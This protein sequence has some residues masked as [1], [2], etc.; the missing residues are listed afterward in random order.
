MY[1]TAC[2]EFSFE[3][4]LSS[5]KDSSGVV[6]FSHGVNNINDLLTLAKEFLKC[7]RSSLNNDLQNILDVLIR[8]IV[9]ASDTPE[10]EFIWKDTEAFINGIIPNDWKFGAYANNGLDYVF[11]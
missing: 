2:K 11:I 8:R 10:K 5:N 7:I 3:K 1:G 4:Y 6:T 9:D